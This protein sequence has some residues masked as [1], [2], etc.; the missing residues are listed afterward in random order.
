MRKAALILLAFLVLACNDDTPQKPEKLLTED[1]MVDVLYDITI[2]QSVK[3]FNPKV[4]R[5]NKIDLPDYVYNKYNIDS[6]VF[7]QNHAYYA[8]QL[9]VYEQIHNRVTDRVKKEK[10][11]F[12]PEQPKTEKDSLKEDKKKMLGKNALK[13]LNDRKENKD[14]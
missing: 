5:E 10:E 14:K 4:L 1:E 8:A 13:K 7:A 9:D 2:L 12:D 3:S 6:T 11:P